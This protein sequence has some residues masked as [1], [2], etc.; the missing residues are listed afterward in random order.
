MGWCIG[1]SKFL[2]TFFQ[3]SCIFLMSWVKE[4]K[5]QLHREGICRV[6]PIGGSMKGA[7]ESGQLVTM[8]KARAEEVQVGD[9]VFIKWKGNFILHLVKEITPAQLLIGNNL[10]KINGWIDKDAVIAKVTEVEGQPYCNSG[11][12]T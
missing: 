3:T 7:I 12:K 4:A 6:R 11:K 1:G 8:V 9:A 2:Q 5:S 10:G